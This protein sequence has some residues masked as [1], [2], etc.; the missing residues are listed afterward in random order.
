MPN[1]IIIQPGERYGRMVIIGESARVNPLVRRVECRCDCGTVKSV[2]FNSLR[3]G[4]TTSCGCLYMETRGVS[5]TV[6][7]DHGSSEYYTWQCMIQ[8]CTNPNNTNWKHYGGR[9]I[10][11]CAEWLHNFSAFLAYM[12]RK[13]EKGYSIDRFP[14]PNGN[15]EPG[16]V[17]WATQRQQL[18]N[19]RG[20]VWI[21]YKGERRLV[22]EVCEET[23]LNYNTVK[24]RWLTGRPESEIFDPVKK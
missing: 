19:K 12:G 1:L 13:P 11:V 9:G 2:N 22:I 7:G 18:R 23:G 17:R 6:H 3:S 5:A 16:N 21:E 4:T 20:N 14:N 24:K 8:R 15:Y 10:K